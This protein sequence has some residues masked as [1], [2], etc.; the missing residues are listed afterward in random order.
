[1]ARVKLYVQNK[2]QKALF[3]GEL[4]GQ[5]SDGM[6][7][8]ATPDDHWK[9]WSTAVVKVSD[10]CFGTNS[11]GMRI[12]R[13]YDFTDINLMV[14]VGN[15]MVSI[16]NM[17]ESGVKPTDVDK[18]APSVT[19]T[20]EGEF[21]WRASTSDYYKKELDEIEKKFG[22]FHELAIK[23]KNGP[24]NDFKKVRAELVQLKRA[25]RTPTECT[26]P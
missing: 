8:D 22:S 5:I 16:A 25:V 26:D 19:G 9:P 24:Y 10:K 11:G 14:A 12:K 18:F 4:K 21:K 23:A 15:R 7:E 1:M 2:V 3:D 6:W 13:N 20:T 17:T